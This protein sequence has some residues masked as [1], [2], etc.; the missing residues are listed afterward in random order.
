MSPAA[1]VGGAGIV[2]RKLPGAQPWF[3]GRSGDAVYPVFH[4]VSGMAKAAG[5]ARVEAVSSDRS[6]IAALAFRDADGGTC[7]W[8]ANLTDAAQHIA[9]P[10]AAIGA[11][12]ARLDESTFEAAAA[13][14][15]FL[16]SER[17]ARPRKKSKSARMASRVSEWGV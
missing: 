8:L 17:A 3:E 1:I 16:Q 5:R 2:H 11:Q 13:D 15:A 4:V 14:P 10:E 12:L 9:L 6:R 7:L